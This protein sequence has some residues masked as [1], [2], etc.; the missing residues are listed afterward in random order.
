[1]LIPAVS[2]AATL[3]ELLVE[4]GVITK[5]EASASMHAG[6]AKVYWNKGTRLEFPDTGFTAKFNTQ[7]QARYRF[8]DLESSGNSSSFSR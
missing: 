3:E 4:K 5:G 7:I 8:N 2:N 6:N 1:M